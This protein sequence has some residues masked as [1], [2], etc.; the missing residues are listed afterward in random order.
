MSNEYKIPAENISR[1]MEHEFSTVTGNFR[2]EH[3][4]SNRNK[5]FA[6]YCTVFSEMTESQ[7]RR[8]ISKLLNKSQ[9]LLN[10]GVPQ[11]HMKF[12]DEMVCDESTTSTNNRAFSW[13]MTKIG[14]TAEIPCHAYVA[15]R[16]WFVCI[17]L[18]LLKV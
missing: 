18:F 14:T 8:N 5:I 11:S 9:A 16:N 12:I 4:G 1:T 13:P 15:T 17:D 7:L 3:C 10:L 2:V 6:I